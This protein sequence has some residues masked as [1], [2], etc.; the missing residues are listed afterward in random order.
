MGADTKSQTTDL[1][2]QSLENSADSNN[3]KRGQKKWKRVSQISVRETN[4][5]PMP[6]MV[7][8]VWTA[9]YASGLPCQNMWNLALM[10]ALDAGR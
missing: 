9:A 8:D 3:V 2:R 7:V 4:A 5:W 1:G 10:L 6:Q